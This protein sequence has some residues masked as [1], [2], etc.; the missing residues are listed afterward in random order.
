MNTTLNV[1]LKLLC[2]LSES[3]VDPYTIEIHVA[4]AYLLVSV[5]Q[6]CTSY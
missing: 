1:G 6:I 2:C 4:L 5:L 3:L